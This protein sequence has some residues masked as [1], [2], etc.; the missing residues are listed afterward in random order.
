MLVSDTLE[1]FLKLDYELGHK[2]KRSKLRH[3]LLIRIE[4]I[5]YKKLPIMAT[6]KNC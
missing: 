4:L 3:C 6:L 1:T 5:N 2:G